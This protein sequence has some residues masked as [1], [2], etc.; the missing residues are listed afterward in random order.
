MHRSEWLIV[1]ALAA[2]TLFVFVAA[3]NPRSYSKP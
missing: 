3:Y 1:D 2:V